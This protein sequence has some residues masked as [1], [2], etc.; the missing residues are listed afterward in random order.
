M[1][2]RDW[3]REIVSPFPQ[4][5][6]KNNPLARYAM[7]NLVPH[8][9]EDRV[10]SGDEIIK[11]YAMPQASADTGRLGWHFNYRG[12]ISRMPFFHCGSSFTNSKAETCTTMSWNS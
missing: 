6:C 8:F 4:P 7:P 9:S 3:V 2:P 5:E 1:G 11:V 10:R 12:Q